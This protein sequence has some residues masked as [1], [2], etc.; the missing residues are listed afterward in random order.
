MR[1]ALREVARAPTR[2]A[3]RRLAAV[4]LSLAT[5]LLGTV[6][7]RG[8]STPPRANGTHSRAAAVLNGG[9]NVGEQD[10]VAL[11]RAMRETGLD[12]LQISYDARLTTWDG[13]DLDF[14]EREPGVLRARVRAARA[15]GLSVMLVLRVRLDG[16]HPSNRH[17]WHGLAWP[18]DAAL[19]AFFAR[20]RDFVLWAADLAEEEDVAMLVIGNE[21]NALTST[22]VDVPGVL[23]RA[24]DHE[25]LA[26]EAAALRRC[27]AEGPVRWHDGG[28]Y[29]DLAS[30]VA[31]EQRALS[32]WGA[33][34][35]G[36]HEGRASRLRQRRRLHDDFWRAT[37]DEARA[38]YRGVL[39]YGAGFD[40]FSEVGFWDATDALVT[41]AYFGLYELG[42]DADRRAFEAAWTRHLES[43]SRVAR[44]RP[45]HPELPVYFGELGFTRRKHSGVRPWSYE[46]FEI[47]PRADGSDACVA[48][49]EV[50]LDPGERARALEGLGDALAR[51]ALPQL[52]GFSLWK[53]TS[54]DTHAALEPY[55]IRLRDALTTETRRARS[56]RPTLAAVA[57]LSALLRAR[58]AAR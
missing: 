49:G 1:N 47:L 21:L 53:I 51:G 3:Y 2:G 23:R 55:A 41:T 30:A 25:Q 9:V 54:D 36:P 10:P 37:L 46:G 19:E 45:S 12:T 57:R 42:E 16:E 31:G 38:H 58:P 15:A 52:R 6:A 24:L 5:L 34:V 11:A 26:R 44:A 33:A 40:S 50:P 17:L 13:A 18:R 35:A 28:S 32:R 48:W 29:P 7:L 56:E 4:A 27:D 14:R 43:V 8:G 39:S 20:Y 22:G